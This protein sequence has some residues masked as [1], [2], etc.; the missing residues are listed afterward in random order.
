V[1]TCLVAVQIALGGC[2]AG[3][4]SGPGAV[5]GTGPVTTEPRT[6]DAFTRVEVDNG[7]G[8]TLHVGAPSA[9]TVSAQANILPLVTTTVENGVLKIRGTESFTTSSGVAVTA[10]MSAL[11]AISIAGGSQV[12]VDGVAGD[13]LRIDLAGGGR[14]TVAG[15][16]ADVVL[17]AGGGAGVELAA[18]TATTMTVDLSGGATATLNISGAVTGGAV[19]TVMGGATLSVRTSGGARVSGG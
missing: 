12:R 4:V 8:L 6:V 13:R 17:V 9:V 1:V 7:I 10:S 19:A 3:A 16:A 18:L 14:I 2:A 15:R 11:D 5:S